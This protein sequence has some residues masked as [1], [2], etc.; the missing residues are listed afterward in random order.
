MWMDCVDYLALLVN[1]DPKDKLA[2][3]DHLAIL[4]HKGSRGRLVQRVVRERVAQKD[5]KAR[6]DLLDKMVP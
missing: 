5:Q 4:V 6:E 1:L 3:L 2:I